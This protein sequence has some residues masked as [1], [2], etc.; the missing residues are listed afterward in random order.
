[1]AT[2]SNLPP[3]VLNENFSVTVTVVPGPLEIISSVSGVLSG[4]PTEPITITSGTT[5]VNISGKHQNTFTDVFSYTEKGETDLTQTPT[6][7][8]G[9]GNVPDKKN[10]FDLK[11]DL[12]RNEI[13]TYILTVNGNQT[14]SVTQE[15]LNPL[16]VKRKFMAN[17]NYNNY[18]G[19]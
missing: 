1:M 3:V 18:K 19:T 13:R 9:L 5:S 2:A 16:E 6:T 17:Y 8:V 7:V 11:Q 14:L 4:S 12:R 10:L 15:V